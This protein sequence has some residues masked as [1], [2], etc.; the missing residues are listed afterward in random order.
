M[1]TSSILKI[2]PYFGKWLEWIG[3]Y[4]ES[5]RHNPDIH[6]LFYTD[7]EKPPTWLPK[8]LRNESSAW[9]KLDKLVQIDIDVAAKKGFKISPEGFT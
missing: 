3:F 1:K 8:S 4:L 5:C 2:I 7:C 6:W 9:M